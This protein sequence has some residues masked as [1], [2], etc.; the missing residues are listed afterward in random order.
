MRSIFIKTLAPA[1]VMAMPTI[2]YTLRQAHQAF[3][4]RRA[5]R[6]NGAAVL[7]P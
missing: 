6:F 3:A 5:G 7:I 2:V 4:D 1:I